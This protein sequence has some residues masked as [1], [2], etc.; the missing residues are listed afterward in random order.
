MRLKIL[1]PPCKFLLA[2]AIRPMELLKP[3]ATLQWH[4][5]ECNGIA[6]H[7]HLDCLLHHLFRRRSKKTLTLH[8]T[9]LCEGNWLVTSGFPSQRASNAENISN[10]WHHHVAVSIHVCHFDHKQSLETRQFNWLSWVHHGNW[11]LKYHPL[12]FKIHYGVNL[13]ISIAGGSMI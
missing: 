10:G 5:N 12:S 3:D 2:R 6:N 4:H 11:Q 8:V 1:V 13:I 9:G 7:Q